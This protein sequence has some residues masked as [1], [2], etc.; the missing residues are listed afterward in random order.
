MA[1]GST[2]QA[3]HGGIFVVPFVGNPWLYLVAIASGTV[4][5]AFL[6]ITLMSIKGAE[7]LQ[8]AEAGGIPV[9]A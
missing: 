7:R 8:E 1:F 2:L 9:N 5:S 6:V 4:L 3:P